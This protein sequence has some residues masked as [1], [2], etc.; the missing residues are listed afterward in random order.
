M[1]WGEFQVG[2]FVRGQA[3]DHAQILEGTS[4]DAELTEFFFVFEGRIEAITQRK[5]VVD[6]WW[7]WKG[8]DEDVYTPDDPEETRGRFIVLRGATNWMDILQQGARWT[9]AERILGD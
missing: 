6:G 5:V 7:I 9:N 1:K 3:D 4:H 2:D 8:T